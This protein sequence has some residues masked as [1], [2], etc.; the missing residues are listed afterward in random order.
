VR[1]PVCAPSAC[2]DAWDR[3]NDWLAFDLAH[4][5]CIVAPTSPTLPKVA[6]LLRNGGRLCPARS[7]LAFKRLTPT[8]SF[9]HKEQVLLR[10][11]ISTK[12]ETGLQS[13][14]RLVATVIVACAGVAGTS[15]ITAATYRS[16]DEAIVSS[17]ADP[18]AYLGYSCLSPD[19]NRAEISIGRINCDTAA[20]KSGYSHGIFRPLHPNDDFSTAFYCE[21]PGSEIYICLGVGGR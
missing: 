1:L 21:K 8:V 10:S 14:K 2:F 18:P 17:M 12:G 6:H 7:T 16:S 4:V 9:A 13:I 5:V 20:E 19:P 3:I 15:D 11:R